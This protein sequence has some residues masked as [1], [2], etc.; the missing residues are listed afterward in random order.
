MSVDRRAV[1]RWMR[2]TG[3]GPTA[4]IAH[5]GLNVGPRTLRL[6]RE[7]FEGELNDEG[8]EQEPEGSAEPV[9]D[10]PPDPELELRDRVLGWLTEEGVAVADVARR[11]RVPVATVRGWVLDWMREREATHATTARRFGVPARVLRVWEERSARPHLADDAELQENADGRL[12]PSYYNLALILQGDAWWEDRMR[13]DE[14]RAVALFRPGV[15]DEWVELAD[16]HER[17]VALHL[18]A[19]WRTNFSRETLHE[20]LI[21]WAEQHR[22]HPVRRFL[23]ASRW[24][25]VRRLDTLLEHY[26]KCEPD[27]VSAPMGRKWLI[28]ACARVFEPGC[29]VDTMLV[30][31]GGQ[32][33]QK[34]TGFAALAGPEWFSDAEMDLRNP[35]DAAMLLRGAWMYE[36]GELDTLRR[37]E[38]TTVKA[39]LS[40]QVDRYRA[41]YGRNP[42]NW[43]RQGILVG[44]TNE[45]AFLPDTTGNR[46]FWVRRVLPGA[47][48][49]VEALRRDREQIWAEAFALYQEGRGKP[50]HWWLTP[51]EEALASEG[52][53]QHQIEHPWV[54]AL[55]G[56]LDTQ[57]TWSRPTTGELLQAVGLDT[58]KARGGDARALAEVMRQLGYRNTRRSPKDRTRV[59]EPVEPM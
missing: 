43:P 12:L 32:G 8:A 18:A 15:G 48:I 59:W 9:D 34:S 28:S 49:D 44:S 36:F 47:A 23:R 54:D 25:G 33:S 29:K 42:A 5:F 13:W 21:W 56:W 2:E 16:E 55:R 27:G 3:L 37:G 30:L 31:A 38:V 1:V 20:G 19:S 4:A 11:A 50:Y 53:E 46:R 35:A 14:F 57:P 52:A 10:E 17:D 24:D 26:F 41:P 45:A 58:A 39:F 40:R 7:K 6:W 51:E 22:V